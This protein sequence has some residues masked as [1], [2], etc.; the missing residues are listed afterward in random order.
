MPRNSSVILEPAKQEVRAARAHY[1]R[2]SPDLGKD[3]T[4]AFKE[5]LTAIDRR[6]RSFPPHPDAVSNETR[7]AV[8]RRFPYLILFSTA[9]PVETVVAAVG[10]TRRGPGYWAGAERRLGG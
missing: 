3:F 7:Y 9:D 4:A 6:P 8:L 10:H 5:G 1:R 2:I